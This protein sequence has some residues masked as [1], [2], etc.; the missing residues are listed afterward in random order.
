MSTETPL[1]T[2]IADNYRTILLR[3]SRNGSAQFDERKA[4]GVITP[5]MLC[6]LDSADKLEFNPTAADAD[7]E[8]LFATEQDLEGKTITDNYALDDIARYVAVKSGDQI[9]A[10]ANA[11]I[12]LNAKVESAGNGKLRTLTT[13]K[14][15]G[16]C[17]NKAAGALD[18][19]F[20]LQII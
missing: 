18:D 10:I 13:G 16:F 19:R 4:A 1:G 5:G 11:A 14:P 2:E 17:S 6:Q 8:L 12:A 20:I 9:Y 7:A 3:D 15:I